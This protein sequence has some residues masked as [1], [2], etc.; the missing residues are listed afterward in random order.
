MSWIGEHR[1]GAGT[2]QRGRWHAC[3]GHRLQDGWGKEIEG[4]C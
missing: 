1:V 2:K 3:N 4:G